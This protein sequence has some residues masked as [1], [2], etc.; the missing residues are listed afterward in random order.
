MLI[1]LLLSSLILS[2]CTGTSSVSK[3]SAP[4]TAAPVT[5][6]APA[7]PAQTTTKNYELKYA[8]NDP[9]NNVN[10]LAVQWFADEL[11][12]RT[13]GRAKLTIYPGE[14]L[15]KA[16]DMPAMLKNR[17]CDMAGIATP[18]VPGAF[19][20]YDA[21]FLP[22]LLPT[23]SASM[24]AFDTCYYNGIFDKELAGYHVLWQQTAD[25]GFLFMRNKKVTKL[26]DLKGLVIRGVS[27]VNTKA[28]EALGASPISMTSAEVYTALQKGTMDGLVTFIDFASSVKLA[29]VCKYLCMY[30]LSGTPWGKLIVINPD[31]FKEL[32]G[33]IQVTIEQ[34]SR[35]ARYKYIDMQYTNP[36]AMGWANKDLFDQAVKLGF[37][38]YYLSPDESARWD[39][40]L[41]PVTDAWIK[42]NEA[43]GLP[44]QKMV[45]LCKRVVQGFER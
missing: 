36:I 1:I 24:E 4:T 6:A 30:P 42:D 38:A 26:E 29:D 34:L 23:A 14:A 11:Q 28:I 44:A 5:S 13:N 41:A 45:D 2:S 37:E 21:S 22:G 8:G 31:L 16:A 18:F 25:V 12:K 43:K 17:I 40:T 27:A 7:Q 39:K 15:G 20:M 33:D 19:P 35:E 3:T 32:P 9:P 10:Y